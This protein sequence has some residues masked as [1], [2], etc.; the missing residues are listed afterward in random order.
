MNKKHFITAAVILTMALDQSQAQYSQVMYYM[1]IP[2]SHLLNPALRPSNA[3]YIGLPVISGVKANAGN[4]F[5]NFSDVFIKD[6][7]TDSIKTFLHPDY[8]IDDF[9]SKTSERNYIEANALV[10]TLGLGFNAGKEGYFSLDINERIEGNIVIPGDLFTLAFKGNES[11]AGA[12]IDLSSLTGSMM[13]FREAGIGYSTPLSNKVRLGVRGKVLFGVG[14]VIISNKALGID[15]SEDYSHTFNADLTVNISGPVT[16]EQDGDQNITGIEV[17][18]SLLNTTDQK[19]RYFSGTNNIG[20]GIDLGA[21]FA[22]TDKFTLSASVIDLGYIKWKDYVTNIT[23]KGEF[24]FDGLDMDGVLDGTQTLEEAGEEILDSLGSV[25]K[26]AVTNESFVTWLPSGVAIGG[27]YNFNRSFSLGLLSY[28]KFIDN[29]I[30]ES[31]TFSGNMNIGTALSAAVSYTFSTM[32]YDNLGA[33]IAARAGIFQV[34]LLA[35]RIP[36]TWNKFKSGGTELPLPSGWNVVNLRVGLN[37]LFGNKI[38]QR[39]DKPIVEII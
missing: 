38:R 19:I 33:G 22:V 23:T 14:S 11:F 26:P 21:T 24:L 6:E 27:G 30:H 17:N 10:Q 9:L 28:T 35:D 5:V 12:S 8:D 3:L 32:A 34:Y 39:E 31:L 20:F 29:S 15:V 16:V 4:N 2:Q 36:L 13:Y 7:A 37:L 1:N 25:F 18:D